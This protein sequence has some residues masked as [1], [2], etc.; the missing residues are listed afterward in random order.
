MNF[1]LM[2]CCLLLTGACTTDGVSISPADESVHATPGAISDACST[3]QG[4]EHPYSTAAELATLIIGQWVRC[5][6]PSPLQDTAQAGGVGIKIDADGTYHVLERDGSGGARPRAGFGNQ[7][8]WDIWD[9]GTSAP[10]FNLH[11]A[12]NQEI[13]LY[14]VFEDDPRKFWLSN[15][16]TGVESQSVYAAL[17]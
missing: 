3:A 17:P 1:H 7:G 4:T 16:A 11:P 13:G 8:A 5:S 6:G 2:T 14:P 12:P 10:Q 9:E 15:I